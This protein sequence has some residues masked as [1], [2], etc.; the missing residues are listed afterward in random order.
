MSLDLRL[1]HSRGR[2]RDEQRQREDD[3][4]QQQVTVEFLPSGP[5]SQAQGAVTTSDGITHR[6]IAR[7]SAAYPIKWVGTEIGYRTNS[8]LGTISPGWKFEHTTQRTAR[9][10]TPASRESIRRSGTRPHRPFR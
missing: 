3:D 1:V 7:A 10:A 4:A 8:G 6:I 9:C 2:R 5:L